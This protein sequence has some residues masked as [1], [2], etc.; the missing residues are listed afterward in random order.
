M[1]AFGAVLFEMLTGR[2]A[3]E[4][5]SRVRVMA[6]VLDKS[7]AVGHPFRLRRAAALDRLVH[8]CLAKRPET[9]GR[10]FEISQRAQMDCVHV[11][12]RRAL[13]RALERPPP[14]LTPALVS[15]GV[16]AA[17]LAAVLDSGP[18][19]SQLMTRS[20][21]CRSIMPAGIRMQYLSDGITEGV[22]RALSPL[23]DLKVMS[24]ASVLRYK[25]QHVDAQM[26]REP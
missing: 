1:F 3:F 11:G 17:L 18:C 16:S 9:D 8:K 23:P 4:G 21:Y 19:A 6:A 14:L 24:G 10:P 20:P 26:L 2:P 7:P 25:G 12:D 13:A 22:I 15:A 5:T